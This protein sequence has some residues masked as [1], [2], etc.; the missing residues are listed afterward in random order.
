MKPGF[1][2][3]LAAS[4]A[5]FALAQGAMAK[6]AGAVRSAPQKEPVVVASIAPVYGLVKEVMAGVAQP[7]ILVP[8][9]VSP[10]VYALRP[11]DVEMLGDAAV[12]Y[13]IGSPLEGFMAKTLSANRIPNVALGDKLPVK[14]KPRVGG[15]WEF[16]DDGDSVASFDPH[17][18]LDPANAEAMVQAIADDLAKRDPAHA[19]RYESNAKAAIAKIQAMDKSIAALLKNDAGKPF[20][21]FHDAY[22]YFEK[23][24]HLSGV[25]SIIVDAEAKPSA[26]RMLALRSR[27]QSDN[28][29]CVFTEPQFNTALVA[30][31]T[32]GTSATHAAID[33]L[34]HGD[35][36]KLV[37]N[38]AKAVHGCLGAKD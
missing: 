10:H 12:V 25:G 27:I 3:F 21:V 35:Y 30:S 2:A 20:I 11:S 7:R 9:N 24:Y 16:D 38:L 5:A 18:W 33:P 32:E 37:E 6:D 19:K 28:V 14:Y 17:M 22:Q 26:K 13:W 4:V 36:F 15:V 29:K 1:L 23:R 8:G 34:G 31:I